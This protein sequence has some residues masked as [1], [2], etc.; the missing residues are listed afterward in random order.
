ME[1]KNFITFAEVVD[2]ISKRNDVGW[3]AAHDIA[4]AVINGNHILVTRE[5]AEQNDFYIHHGYDHDDGN[6]I[7]L[8]ILNEVKLDEL[9]I[10]FD[11]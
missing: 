6:R 5:G 10:I 9:Y 7:I 1:I 8:E 3:N 11:D 2:F 4:V